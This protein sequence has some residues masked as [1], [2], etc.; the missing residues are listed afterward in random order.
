MRY[1]VRFAL[2][3][4]SS[5][6]M[7]IRT[8]PVIFKTKQEAIAH[9]VTWNGWRR[10]DAHFRHHEE[11]PSCLM[12][13]EPVDPKHPLTIVPGLTGTMLRP[14]ESVDKTG[15]GVDQGLKDA[16]YGDCNYL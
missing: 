1:M 4:D 3:P 2:V 5:T 11:A 9:A 13:V 6:P 15:D 10:I 16:Y 8:L 12:V 7:P 14:G